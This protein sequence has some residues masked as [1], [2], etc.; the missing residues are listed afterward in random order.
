MTLLNYLKLKTQNL[1]TSEY[2]WIINL[3]LVLGLVLGSYKYSFFDVDQVVR[4]KSTNTASYPFVFVH[5]IFGSIWLLAGFSQFTQYSRKNIKIHKIVGGVYFISCFI[6]TISLLI[7]N[8]K[9]Q[10]KTPFGVGSLP[11]SVYT[12]VCLFAGLYYLKVRNIKLHRAWMI[13]SMIMGMLMPFDRFCY[14]MSYEFLKFPI[15]IEYQK[16]I[17]FIVAELIIHKR[18]EF[19]LLEPRKRQRNIIVLL[20]LFI[21]F[22]FIFWISFTAE[23]RVVN[24]RAMN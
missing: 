22:L 10:D 8:I 9:L 4:R 17:V 5:V 19:R 6:S 12:F 13:R 20:L 3:A 15:S 11:L 2:F 16:V 1:K 7:I 18:L 14:G 24:S 23:L 21:V